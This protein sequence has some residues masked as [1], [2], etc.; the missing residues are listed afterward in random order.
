M[1]IWE[2]T[3]PALCLPHRAEP[4]SSWLAQG[5]PGLVSAAL[6]HLLQR[7]SL[8]HHLLPKETM[9]SNSLLLQGTHTQEV[10]KLQGRPGSSW[11]IHC[12]SQQPLCLQYQETPTHQGLRE[13]TRKQCKDRQLSQR[14]L[15]QYPLKAL[16][17]ETWSF[18]SS[19]CPFGSSQFWGWVLFQ[20]PTQWDK[21][22]GKP[23]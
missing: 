23:P 3:P 5:P 18:L 22:A 2:Q 1:C 9:A 15:Q 14:E 12:R 4:H 17:A 10:L 6:L 19:C 13:E 21:P 11:I 16:R 20:W 7:G 8:S